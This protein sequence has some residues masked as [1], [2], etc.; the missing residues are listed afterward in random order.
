[1]L[2]ALGIAVHDCRKS[3]F[4]MP[5]VAGHGMCRSYILRELEN[6]FQSGRENWAGDLA[7][8]LSGAVHACNLADGAPF[9]RSHEGDRGQSRPHC[10]GRSRWRQGCNPLLRLRDHRDVV[11]LFT[12][13]PPVPATNNIAE[14]DLGMEKV[15]Q[16]YSG[17]H[18]GME[19]AISR[20]I[21][22]T[23]PATG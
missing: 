8:L 7:V 6:L 19:G 10:R 1:M 9:P 2:E 11:L 20:T 17:Y 5:H 21:I 12:R 23:V 14:L 22:R 3:C 16:G 15:K 4:G 13:N 18:C